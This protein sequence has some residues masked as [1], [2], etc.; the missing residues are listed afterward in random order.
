[1]NDANCTLSSEGHKWF[2]VLSN[3]SYLLPAG[4]TAYKMFKPKGSQM[5]KHD[6]AE[7]IILFIFVA[8]F[9]S[10]SYH[11]CRADLA[12]ST[13]V[14][15]CEK[16]ADNTKIPPCK[17]CPKTTL[18]WVYELPGSS[19]ERMTYEIS[20]FIDHFAAT[21]TLLMVV[22]HTIPITE[23]LRKLIMVVSIIWVIICLSGGNDAFALLPSLMVVIV[24]LVFWFSLRDQKPKGFYTR[25][26]AWT[27]ALVCTSAALFFFNVH[28]EPY[29]LHHSLWHILGATGAAF[30][31][32]KTA[33]CYQ[34]IDTTK[35]EPTEWMKHIFVTPNECKEYQK[36]LKH[37]VG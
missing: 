22:I 27:S 33:G 26:K 20:R 35:F 15:V 36:I 11:S 7:L 1:M 12:V 30:L 18:S 9:G 4:V 10:W 24:L 2:L 37:E 28:T 5:N 32:S 17:V 23:K 34:D 14:D 19:N 31:I 13:G 8:F 21:F 25:N 3:L 16:K 6:G 29:W